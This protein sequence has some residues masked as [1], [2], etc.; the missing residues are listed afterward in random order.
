[1]AKVGGER[2]KADGTGFGKGRDWGGTDILSIPVHGLRMVRGCRID[3]A[4]G[5]ASA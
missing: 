1:L 2:E 4:I 5:A 3:I